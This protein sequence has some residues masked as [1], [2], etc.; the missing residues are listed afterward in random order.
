MQQYQDA[1]KLLLS[2]L[3]DPRF[4]F[5]KK[6][7]EHTKSVAEVMSGS[8]PEEEEAAC[9]ASEAE[10]VWDKKTEKRFF[11]CCSAK[12]INRVVA[13]RSAKDSAAAEE[14]PS[15]ESSAEDEVFSGKY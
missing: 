10:E 5:N 9:S 2:T 3:I 4:K 15:G 14:S 11:D 7:V 6:F 8:E 12:L 13:C 1:E